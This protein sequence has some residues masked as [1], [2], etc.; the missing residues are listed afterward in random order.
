M[1][2]SASSPASRR[3]PPL[4]RFTLAATLIAVVISVVVAIVGN[5]RATAGIPSEARISP[6]DTSAWYLGMEHAVSL[7]NDCRDDNER[8]LR[9]L[10]IRARETNIRARL[11]SSAAE[12]YIKGFEHSLRL[13]SDSL[14][15]VILGE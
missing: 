8:A 4:P 3:R 6:A 14:S 12:A 10:D 15:S 13:N 2:P 1:T 11:G 9:L 5:Y 7:V